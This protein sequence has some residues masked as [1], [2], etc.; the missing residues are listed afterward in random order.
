MNLAARYCDRIAVFK[1]GE[2]IA[3]DK[4]KKVLTTELVK[5]AFQVETCQIETPIGLQICT[6]KPC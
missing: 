6:I 4:M 2:L 5:A 1:N 3:L